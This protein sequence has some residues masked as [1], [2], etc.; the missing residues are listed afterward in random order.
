M[1]P[2]ILS[3]CVNWAQSHGSCGVE[4]EE[5]G[6][7][8]RVFRRTWDVDTFKRVCVATLD[9]YSSDPHQEVTALGQVVDALGL[10]VSV[11]S[12][13]G[14]SNVLVEA[15]CEYLGNGYPQKLIDYPVFDLR[16]FRRYLQRTA[17]SVFGS[18]DGL[19]MTEFII[20][21]L[22]GAETGDW[23]SP[24]PT[25]KK[26][27]LTNDLGTP[28]LVDAVANIIGVL[29]MIVSYLKETGRK[30]DGDSLVVRSSFYL[31][32]LVHFPFPY[33]L[34]CVLFQKKG[35]DGYFYLDQMARM[36]FRL[37]HLLLEICK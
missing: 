15:F 31:V 12:I 11:A 25:L 3:R 35:N 8:V 18:L 7:K 33:L 17:S 21:R 6:D 34:C 14:G 24:R 13:S 22:K 26:A 19:A 30:D 20:N 36:N 29:P 16:F 10:D 5:E 27:I 37:L 4:F 32:V 1:Y 28:H 2:R 23:M 9:R